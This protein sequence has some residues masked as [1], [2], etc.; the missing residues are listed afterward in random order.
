MTVIYGIVRI[1]V[2]EMFVSLNIYNER[3]RKAGLTY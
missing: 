1:T 2:I 3:R